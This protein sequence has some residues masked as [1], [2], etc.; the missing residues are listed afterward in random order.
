MAKTIYMP[1]E[2]WDL[3]HCT[4]SHIF[5]LIPKLVSEPLSKLMSGPSEPFSKSGVGVHKQGVQLSASKQKPY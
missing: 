4:T 5:N 1:Y 2:N 3:D